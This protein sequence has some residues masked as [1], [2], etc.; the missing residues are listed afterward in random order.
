MVLGWT[1][2][3]LAGPLAPGA[4]S[5]FGPRGVCLHADGSLWISDTGHHR[6]LGWRKTPENDNAPAEILIGQ[7]GFDHEGRNAKGPPG[8][9]RSTCRLEYA[10]GVVVWRSP[11]PGTTAC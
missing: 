8:R 2:G 11:T 7:P 9:P 5:L 1:E 3:D 10:R 4:T 6:L